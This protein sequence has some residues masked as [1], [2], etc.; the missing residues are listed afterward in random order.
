VE[1]AATTPTRAGLKV[2]ASIGCSASESGRE[3]LVTSGP[4][5]MGQSDL[6]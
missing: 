5:P 3:K 1:D 4:S 2:T 6:E